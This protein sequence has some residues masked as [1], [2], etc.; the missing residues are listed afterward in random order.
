MTQRLRRSPLFCLVLALSACDGSPPPES[1]EESAWPPIDATLK[2]FKPG[3]PLATPDTEELARRFDY[4]QRVI[5]AY[6]F[7]YSLRES[8]VTRQELADITGFDATEDPGDVKPEPAEVMRTTD[9]PAGWDSRAVGV[10][11]P[12]VR[13][14]GSCGSCWAFGTVAAVEAAIAQ[15]ENRLVNLSEQYVLDCSGRGTCGG[16]YWA[17]EFVKRQGL[18]EEPEYPYKGFEQR[19]NRAVSRPVTIE[20]Y[21]RVQSGDLDAMKAA[22]REHGAIGVTMSVCGSIPGYGG[23]VYDSSE[24][25]GYATN[26]IVALVG[27]DDTVQHR[28]GRGA[29]ILRNSWGRGWGEDGYGYFAYGTARLAEDPTYVVYRPEDPTDTD[30]DGVR[31][32]RDNCLDAANADQLDADLD[33]QGDACD[34]TFEAFERPLAL[35]DD[36]SRKVALGFEFPFFGVR[37][38][39]VYVNS[40]GNLT[41][42]ASDDSSGV[43]DRTRFLTGPARIAALYAD[44]NP[45]VGGEVRWGK[46]DADSAYFVY[47]DV[48]RLDGRG[49][50]TFRIT[51]AKNGAITLSFERVTGTGYLVGL[52]AGG[53]RNSGS[54]QELT[55]GERGYGGSTAVFEAFS[56]NEAFDLGGQTL[57]FLAEAGPT[58][59]PVETA[60]RLSD[61]GVAEVPLGFAFPYHGQSYAK[62]LIHADGHLTFG[63]ADTAT[64][65][66][67]ES[68]FLAGPPRI[69]ALFADLDPSRG[70]AVTYRQDPDGRFTV[71]YASVPRFQG[72]GVVD[73]KVVLFADGAVE[74]RYGQV[75]RGAAVVGLTPGEGATA[76]SVRLSGRAAPISVVERETI[77]QAFANGDVFDL[78]GRTVRFEPK[79]SEVPDEAPPA[80]PTAPPVEDPPVDEVAPPAP[81]AAP[82]P[83]ASAEFLELDDDDF[84]EVEIG[85]AFPFHGRSYARVFI[86]ADGNLTFG[87][88]DAS[89]SPRTR[90]RVITGP[91]RIAPLFVDLDPSAGGT[92]SYGPS[93]SGGFRVQW[94]QV[95]GW[96]GGG[97]H[98]FGVTL[99]RDGKIRMD[100]TA[101]TSSSAVVG[102]SRGGAANRS[103]S[104]T[105]AQLLGGSHA[106][107]VT[108]ALTANLT[109][110]A[111]AQLHGREVE[112]R[113]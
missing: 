35:T 71:H 57:V 79:V 74:L 4:H 6:E 107:G 51:L 40:D 67:S 39:E 66:R 112:F 34:S 58:P 9:L 45:A 13:Q 91:P 87:V 25:N 15:S 37:Y 32:L 113:P 104:L 85:F 95:P 88:G 86:N 49:K 52:S 94:T 110:G 3:P 108:G 5:E 105:V 96:R 111:P 98:S 76:R 7:S 106:Y 90:D 97:T 30:Q 41:F 62:A 17:Y 64:T 84:A 82:N 26:H 31:D 60:L 93:D 46:A 27:W 14:Q 89:S 75:S 61:D 44:L 24:C 10:G 2:Y 102:V 48:A 77:H 59:P 72:G 38:P 21:H 23:G 8:D 68:R 28:R 65:S 56:G 20:S 19:C 1:E 16:G 69:A 29:W 80:P 100:W 43:R 92:V 36:D 50:A 70:G 83:P 42:G 12:P 53:E 103:T 63:R 54:E 47:D 18:A 11:L 81:E 101:A 99:E 55:P 109:E 73:A 78:T 22:I 33:G